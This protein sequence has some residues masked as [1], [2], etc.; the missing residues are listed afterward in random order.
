MKITS[1]EVEDNEK[2]KL[3]SDQRSCVGAYGVPPRDQD[4]CEFRSDDHAGY[5]PSYGPS[6]G[7]REA[8]GYGSRYG[9][10]NGVR[11][12]PEHRPSYGMRDEPGSGCGYGGR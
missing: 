9:P 8:P 1:V 3:T 7:V 4:T 2:E 10:S 5:G 6:Y 12:A 11:E